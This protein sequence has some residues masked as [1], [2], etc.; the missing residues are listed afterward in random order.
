MTQSFYFTRCLVFVVLALGATAC[1]NS[2]ESDR[3]GATGDI[4]Q[5]G[6]Q[7]TSHAD[8]PQ[9]QDVDAASDS[10]DVVKDRDVAVDVDMVGSDVLGRCGN[11]VLDANEV[12][13]GD[14]V[15]CEGSAIAPC[16]SDCSG[17][18]MTRCKAQAV[19]IKAIEEKCDD[20]YCS[21]VGR[22][23][24]V[25]GSP[26][27]DCNQGYHA[28]ALTCKPNLVENPCEGVDCGARG[29]CEVI[30]YETSVVTC[31]CNE[32]YVNVAQRCL[33]SP[34]HGACVPFDTGIGDDHCVFEGDLM[35]PPTTLLLPGERVQ[36]KNNLPDVVDH[37]EDYLDDLF[38]G[39]S[40]QGACGTCVVFAINH[41]FEAMQAEDGLDS[42]T[43]SQSHAWDLVDGNLACTNGTDPNSAAWQLSTGPFLVPENAWPYLCTRLPRDAN[44]NPNSCYG[45]LTPPPTGM[46]L[47]TQGLLRGLAPSNVERD[48][49]KIEEALASGH[50][51]LLAVAV[52]DDRWSGTTDEIIASPPEGTETDGYHAI[53]AVGYDRNEQTI[54]FVNSW[55]DRWK[56]D[57]FAKLTYDYVEKYSS[58]NGIYFRDYLNRICSVN[59]DC[60]CGTCVGGLCTPGVEV[61]NQQDDDCDSV[62]DEG[63]G[64]LNGMIRD[65]AGGDQG[66]CQ[67][68]V[69][70]CEGG[71]WGDCLGTIVGP[72]AEVCDGEDNDCDGEPD[73]ISGCGQGEITA[74]DG[75]NVVVG[76]FD[77]E[78]EVSAPAGL[79]KVN[80]VMTWDGGRQHLVICDSNCAGNVQRFDRAVDPA[81]LGVPSGAEITLGLWYR[82]L[83]GI[84]AGPFT[85]TTFIWLASDGESAGRIRAPEAGSAHV[86]RFNVDGTV[87]SAAPIEKV[88]LAMHWGQNQRHII[89]ICD[90]NCEGDAMT[91][92]QFIDPESFG[93]VDDETILISLWF[94]D[95]NNVTYGGFDERAVL[96]F[97]AAECGNGLVEAGEDCDGENLSGASCISQLLT[98]GSIACSSN[99]TFDLRGCELTNCGDGII[100][101]GEDCDGADLDGIDCVSK[102]YDRGMLRC[103]DQCAFDTSQCANDTCQC[104]SGVCCDGCFFRTSSTA[105]N[106]T[107]EGRCSGSQCGADI[108]TRNATTYCSGQSSSCDGDVVTSPWSVEQNCSSGQI[109]VNS[110]AS[111]ASCQTCSQTCS[112]GVCVT[113]VNGEV[114]TE[115]CDPSATYCP[116]GTR[117][118]TC[119]GGQWGAFGACEASLRYYGD[120]ATHCDDGLCLTV[121]GSSNTTLTGVLS[122]EPSGE[123]FTNNVSLVL[124][125]PSTGENV[126]YGCV[127]TA[128]EESYSF[129]INLADFSLSLGGDLQ[130]RAEFFSP[131]TAGGSYTTGF[132]TISQCG[133]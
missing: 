65:C 100:D 29:V 34:D 13:D 16:L 87:K 31:V 22:C 104:A 76:A 95:Q 3:G 69:Q 42:V 19:N 40:N 128:S 111:S 84:T 2:N 44:G 1:A 15:A 36:Q 52:F 63:L 30:D 131:C 81:T 125:A 115:S 62:V 7:E 45:T 106:Q 103:D 118:R 126:S 41:A 91:F 46:N 99:C 38:S 92:S 74:P 109:C 114:D 117:T 55:G 113:C 10:D 35:M 124:H 71:A 101:T 90:G 53:L 89:P 129:P 110:G 67:S 49:A 47:Q 119:N 82:G 43:L 33:L 32:G 75:S 133:Q 28:K 25:E 9:L 70:R 93:V 64:C 60:A 5:K 94:R 132:A 57:G 50:N 80:V 107:S 66:L 17:Y 83:D 112:S 61:Y 79:A 73:E 4:I 18:D 116:L 21:G 6:D 14:R 11:G 108:E 39:P 97:R 121:S 48:I 54:T 86:G 23:I 12:C 127:P 88:S 96:W 98:P 120:A 59:D 78:G 58:P 24:V 8:T 56:G 51:I 27:C 123:T 122:K 105:C 85:P 102:G 20:V 77:V 130:L 26:H 68:G 37:R 72:R